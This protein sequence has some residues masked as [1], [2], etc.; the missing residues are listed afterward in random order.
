MGRRIKDLRIG[1][2]IYGFS[3]DTCPESFGSQA[4]PWARAMFHA[5]CA[6]PEVR[7]ISRSVRRDPARAG[8]R[9]LREIRV[10][11][12]T[13]TLI[14]DYLLLYVFRPSKVCY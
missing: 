7:V 2:G 4:A 13:F 14:K 8:L 5:E 1:F 9:S 6:A 12:N 3:W 11:R 10:M